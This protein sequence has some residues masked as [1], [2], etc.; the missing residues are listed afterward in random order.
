MP[1]TDDIQ[2]LSLFD[3]HGKPAG[4]VTHVLF[5][6]RE[7]RAVGLQVQP[8]AFAYVIARK[9][10]FLPLSEVRLG[11]QR[12]TLLSARPQWGRAA[13]KEQGFAWDDSVIWRLMPVFTEDGRHLGL[14]KDVGVSSADGGVESLVLTGGAA[15]DIAVGRQT[16]PG[17]LVVGFDP[18]RT[19]VLVAGEAAAQ[20]L[21]GGVAA[22]A[23]RGAAVAKAAA[24][25]AAKTALAGAGAAARAAAR[26]GVGKTVRKKT[27]SGWRAF[28][29][30]YAEGLRDDADTDRDG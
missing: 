17:D 14:V 29:D 20:E 18:E 9:P 25:A 24:G 26:S 19:V 23:G 1:L 28:K 15:A 3:T 12:V 22:V 16:I 5:H 4:E 7:P 10:R 27:S 13:E 8:P 30:A 6:P 2:G 21:P 11:A